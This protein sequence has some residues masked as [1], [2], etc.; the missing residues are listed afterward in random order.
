MRHRARLSFRFAARLVAAALL[1]LPLAACLQAVGSYGRFATTEA[2]PDLPFRNNAFDVL[3][4]S[5]NAEINQMA[6]VMAQMI[7]IR[8]EQDGRHSIIMR[9][10]P[11][12]GT[13]GPAETVMAARYF[14][15]PERPS[16][17]AVSFNAADF[18]RADAVPAGRGEP[19]IHVFIE[20]TADIVQMLPFN[21]PAITAWQPE[22]EADRRL[23]DQVLA[24]PV[25]GRGSNPTTL[26]ENAAQLELALRTASRLPTAQRATLRLR[27]A[28]TAPQRQPAPQATAPARPA[29]GPATAT[30]WRF[31]ESRDP[32]TRV[33]T[34]YANLPAEPNQAGTRATFQ[35]RCVGQRLQVLFENS[36]LPLRNELSEGRVRA[37]LM[38]INIDDRVVHRLMWQIAERYPDTAVDPFLAGPLIALAGMFNVDVQGA[39]TDWNAVW[40]INAMGSADS[41]V[42]RVWDARHTPHVLRFTP[43]VSVDELRRR[44]PDCVK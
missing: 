14:A 18:A 29:P 43:R 36:R 17:L 33:V 30:A 37:A 13:A 19:I 22:A 31:G 38:E 2:T 34:Q 27:D 42:L 15:L 3:G 35:I 28:A 5:T 12:P 8:V 9:N 16:V 23:R 40:L 21:R 39:R 44:M 41:V 26:I 7:T 1:A 11:R 20:K 10:T 32:V 25:E 4:Q 6:L 24:L